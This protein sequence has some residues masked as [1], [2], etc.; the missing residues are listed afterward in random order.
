VNKPRRAPRRAVSGVLLLDKPGGM[1]SNTAL[2]VA[3]RLLNA[4][5]A[6]HTGTLDPL[7]TGLLP[8]CFGEA[9]KFA[10]ELLGAD[11]TYRATLRL[12]VTTDTADADGVVLE[13]RPVNVSAAEFAAVLD[14]FRGEIE[15][16]PPMHS[17]LKRDGKPLYEYAR[18]GIE[19]ERAP[20]HVTIR[21]LQLL[22]FDGA[23]AEIEVACSKGT[24][25][26]TLAADIG[27]ALG[28]GAHLTALRRTRI[29]GLD[30]ASAVPLDRLEALAPAE[31]DA[32]LA[33][34]DSLV[35]DLPRA[36]LGADEAER[37]RQG[38]AVRWPALAGGRW[39]LYD[40]GGCFMGLA[41]MAAEGSLRPKRLVAAPENAATS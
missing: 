18:Q 16:V 21:Q 34:V 28:C 27:T 9:T 17:A 13:T 40:A 12:G 30:V 19:L 37:M 8:L 26:R 10:S 25:V 29:G 15:Q 1:T 14:R 4:A 35:G 39:R 31:R 5:K 11:K 2:Q 38:Q 23:Q 7:A 32:C 41:E 20:R 36:D 33:P 3:R 22:A 24:Y 6:G